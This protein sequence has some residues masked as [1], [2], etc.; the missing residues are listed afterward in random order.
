MK[1]R[2]CIPFYKEYEACK[3]G[4]AELM[5]CKEHE[6]IIEPRQGTYIWELRNSLI[7]DELSFEKY[8]DPLDGFDAFLDIDSDIDFTLEQVLSMINRKKDIVSLP[9]LTH[10]VNDE[11]QCGEFRE[12]NGAISKR[13]TTSETGFKKIGWS[14]NG[15][16]LT[17]AHVFSKTEYPWY[18]HPMIVV[19]NTQKEAGEDVGFSMG[20]RKAG[21]DIWCDFDNPVKH[22]LRTQSDFDW[23]NKGDNMKKTALEV[24]EA[25]GNIILAGLKKLPYEVS[26]DLIGNIIKQYQDKNRP[27]VE[28]VEAEQI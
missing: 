5:C 18:R 1:I 22:K 9:Y 16:R 25:E 4:I 7:N 6:F 24:T 12:I 21:F 13:Y 10:K 28:K 17:M 8:Q 19:G 14:G 11:Y 23:S 27:V 20:V 3:K 15:M 2:V 26:A